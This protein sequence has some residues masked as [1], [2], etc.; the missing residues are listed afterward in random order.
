VPGVG[1]GARGEFGSVLLAVNFF[2][3]TTFVS[4]QLF[5]TGV[6]ARKAAFLAVAEAVASRL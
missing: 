4:M 2:K 5:G 3:G 6:G 1:D